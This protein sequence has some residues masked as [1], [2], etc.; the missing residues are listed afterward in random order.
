MSYRSDIKSVFIVGLVYK[1]LRLHTS[2]KVIFMISLL[3]VAQTS[4]ETHAIAIEAKTSPE[5]NFL[6]ENFI[7][8]LKS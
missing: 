4:S 3:N 7:V 6:N 8:S 1:Y 5:E 2:R